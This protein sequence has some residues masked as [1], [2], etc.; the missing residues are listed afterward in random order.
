MPQTRQ[1]A[2]CLVLSW[3]MAAVEAGYI[4]STRPPFQ[5]NSSRAPSYRTSSS[6]HGCATFFSSRERASM[7][8]PHEQ[9]QRVASRG[10]SATNTRHQPLPLAPTPEE[11]DADALKVNPAARAVV[12][13]LPLGSS[14]IPQ[15]WTIH[16]VIFLISC[17]RGIGSNLSAFFS[18]CDS[19]GG[20][21]RDV[22]A[23]GYHFHV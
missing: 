13:H 7:H 14:P 12:E 19:S 2:H 5:C 17:C 11:L 9:Q 6:S 22:L 23:A 16:L 8:E 20:G 3:K 10:R 18:L 4:R 1:Q 15:L 21:R